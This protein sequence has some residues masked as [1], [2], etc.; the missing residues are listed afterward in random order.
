[1]TRQAQLRIIQTVC[2]VGVAADAL[3][4]IALIWPQL[5][6]ILTGR[7][8]LQTD[9]F[10]RLAMAIAASLMLGW[11]LLLAWTAR[12]PIE[13]RSVLLITLPVLLGISLVT[14]IGHL[15]GNASSLWIL[16][17]C[18]F[19]SLALLA[20]YRMANTIA[21]EDADAIDH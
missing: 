6:G 19:L 16:L 15:T 1:M 13:R 21:R 14:L 7:P 2:W 4:A 17:K 5:Y 9:L 12:K 11:T 20:A 8:H 10:S 18:A 3:W